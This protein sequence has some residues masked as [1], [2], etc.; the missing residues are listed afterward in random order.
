MA[1]EGGV[2]GWVNRP[3]YCT[4]LSADEHAIFDLL[5][6]AVHPTQDGN[7]LGINL[8][9]DWEPPRREVRDINQNPC[10]CPEPEHLHRGQQLGTVT[11]SAGNVDLVL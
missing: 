11:P 7:V 1:L 5:P 10:L 6:V 9:E 4:C 2:T 8:R 3:D